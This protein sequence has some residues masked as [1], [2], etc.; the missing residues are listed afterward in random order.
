MKLKKTTKP[1]Q[2]SDRNDPKK[3]KKVLKKKKKKAQIGAAREMTKIWALLRAVVKKN[4]LFT[5]RL[6][7]RVPPPPYGQPGRKKTVFFYD[8]P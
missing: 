3:V 5:V 2:T 8:R 6:T 1:A 7:V 4:G